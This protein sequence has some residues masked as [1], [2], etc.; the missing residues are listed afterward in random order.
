MKYNVYKLEVKPFDKRTF[1]EFRTLA[2]SKQLKSFCYNRYN[3]FR[4]D[5]RVSKKTYL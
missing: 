4:V 1:K 5:N 3:Y 2:E